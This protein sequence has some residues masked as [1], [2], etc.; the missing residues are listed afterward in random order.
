MV[1]QENVMWEGAWSQKVPWLNI[2]DPEVSA[3]G[4]VD[5]AELFSKGDMRVGFLR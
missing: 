5:R 4:P 1:P 3:R 2:G